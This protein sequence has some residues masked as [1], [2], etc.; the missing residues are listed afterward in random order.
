M[1]DVFY[2]FELILGNIFL[3]VSKQWFEEI[4]AHANNMVQLDFIELTQ[5]WEQAVVLM[6]LTK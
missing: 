3:P 4:M 2:K 5:Y 6:D 1:I